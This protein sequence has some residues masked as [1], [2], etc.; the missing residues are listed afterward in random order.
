MYSTGH[1]NRTPVSCTFVLSDAHFDLSPPPLPRALHLQD[2]PDM[3]LW[4]NAT[5][6]ESPPGTGDPEDDR[7]THPLLRSRLSPNYKQL[8]EK[9]AYKAH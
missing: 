1:A 5:K 7:P 2:T 9:S 6:A 4:M 3:L 8:I